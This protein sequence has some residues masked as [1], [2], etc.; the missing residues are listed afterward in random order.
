MNLRTWRVAAWTTAAC[1]LSQGIRTAYAT[2]L[3]CTGTLIS[4]Y[5]TSDGNVVIQGNWRNDYN[6]DGGYTCSNLPT[7][8]NALVPGYFMVTQ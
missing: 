4:A 1:L 6:N 7:Y 3:Y 8:A 2:Q 5:I